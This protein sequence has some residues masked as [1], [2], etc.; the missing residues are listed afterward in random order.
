MSDC[1]ETTQTRRKWS[2]LFLSI[3]RNNHQPRILYPVKL[4]LKN[5]REIRAFSDKQTLRKFVASD[6]LCKKY[7]NKF[8]REKKNDIGQKLR[9]A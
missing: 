6:P 3:E 5:E 2:E 8:F 7:S 9:F 4:S 1:S